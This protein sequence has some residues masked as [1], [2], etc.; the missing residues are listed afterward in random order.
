[1]T[2]VTLHSRIIGVEKT[3]DLVI[4]HGLLGSADNWHTLARQ[5]AL[6][7]RVHL[8]DAR[9]HGRSPH[10]QDHSYELMASDLLKYLDDN[11]IEKACLLGH[12][13][14]GK[15]VML[16]AET[17][18][19][20]VSKLIVADISP[21]EY[22]PQHEPIFQALKSTNPAIANSRKEVLSVLE[23]KLG[24]D[25]VLIPFLMKNLRREKSGGYSWRFNLEVLSNTLSGI[26]K[27][28]DLSVNTI[29]TLLIYGALSGY[30]S[31][32]DISELE[33][34]YLQMENVCLENSGH[35]LHAEEPKLFLESTS[36]FLNS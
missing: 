12:S 2:A 8:I 22:T 25:K 32:E 35:W 23:S 31:S 15:T 21:K 33:E 34:L 29:P 24:E 14:G 26:T 19:D 1:M 9:N 16:F 7:F 27:R 17:H 3:K 28:I 4:L 13:M 10:S 5:Y 36:E 6:E 30:V 11:S 18:P 20:R